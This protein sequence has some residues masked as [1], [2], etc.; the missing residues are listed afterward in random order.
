MRS[1]EECASEGLD[2][3]QY[4]QIFIAVVYFIVASLSNK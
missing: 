3:Y 2:A 1:L 4:K